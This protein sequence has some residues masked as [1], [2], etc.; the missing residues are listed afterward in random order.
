M[1]DKLKVREIGPKL[2]LIRTGAAAQ[3][4]NKLVR[5]SADEVQY[6]SKN[7]PPD[8]SALD[9]ISDVTAK[10]ITNTTSLKELLPDV[11]LAEEIMVSSILSPKDMLDSK[12]LYTLSNNSEHPEAAAA[13]IET[14]ED[15]F[16]NELGLSDNQSEILHEILFQS[17]SY[18]L[19]I[20]PESQVDSVINSNS[21]VS[22]EH[23]R[24]RTVIGSAT[25]LGIL[26]QGNNQHTTSKTHVNLESITD[27]CRPP[28][29][30]LNQ[31]T[32]V[33]DDF[34]ALKLPVQLDLIRNRKIRSILQEANIGLEARKGY[35]VKETKSKSKEDRFGESLFKKRKFVGKELVRLSYDQYAKNQSHPLVMRFPSEATIPVFV[36]GDTGNHVG[37]FVLIDEMGGV[38]SKTKDAD[39]YNQIQNNFEAQQNDADSFINQ[40]H[41]AVY[42][43]KVNYHQLTLQ[44][45]EEYYAKTIEEDLLA[46]L[47]NGAYGEGLDIAKNSEV[48]RLMLGRALAK[49][50]TRL[51]FIPA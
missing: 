4:I 8:S 23:V 9:S 31:Y 13:F 28:N 29:G 7:T 12:L 27:Y 16:D 14:V 33:S 37:Y 32:E 42:G 46:R 35:G 51:I 26:G 40:T 38:I 2:K 11:E 36:K 10:K 34:T 22:V 21:T 15:Y 25:H 50:G 48:Y 47:K 20:I 44:Q 41:E 3:I 1:A 45:I 30:V 43:K 49:M 17:G 19:A 18:I 24:E 6:R 39:Y 5:S